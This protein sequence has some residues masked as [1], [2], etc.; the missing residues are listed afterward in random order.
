M[1]FRTCPFPF[2]PMF[3]WDP[4]KS[5]GRVPPPPPRPDEGRGAR[6]GP[7][8]APADLR[9]DIDRWDCAERLSLEGRRRVRTLAGRE[10]DAATKPDDEDVEA[11][12]RG[13]EG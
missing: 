7:G 9:G 3:R 8:E 5:G 1:G 11:T 10:G 2:S 13:D 12:R 4:G 6:P